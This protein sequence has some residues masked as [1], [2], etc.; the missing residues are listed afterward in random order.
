MPKLL[1]TLICLSLFA[2]TIPAMSLAEESAPETLAPETTG[3]L[4][5]AIPPV[6]NGGLPS[7]AQPVGEIEFG[8]GG[9]ATLSPDIAEQLNKALAERETA[10]QSPWDPYLRIAIDAAIGIGAG[11]ITF[12]IFWV[13]K[14]KTN[15]KVTG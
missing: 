8:P 13:V 14:N 6:G 15:K 7:D 5:S 10:K 3:S 9:Q 12:S 11:L 4:D 2:V 1:L